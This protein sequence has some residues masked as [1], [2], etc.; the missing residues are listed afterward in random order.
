MKSVQRTA[1]LAVGTSAIT[2]AVVATMTLN[3]ASQPPS[4]S[5]NQLR[6]LAKTLATAVLKHDIETI[7]A[8]DRPDL[9]LDDRAALR[10]SKSD[11]YCFLFNS[12]HSQVRAAP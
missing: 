10:D 1:R 9:R 7:L 12:A 11:L 5:L 8:H 6:N 2:I 3:A 4:Q